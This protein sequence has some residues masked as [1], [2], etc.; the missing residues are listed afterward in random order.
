MT[1]ILDYGAT[2]SAEFTAC[3]TSGANV[4]LVA[5]KD[6]ADGDAIAIYG[7][8]VAH[9]LTKPTAVATVV[10]AP[11]STSHK[12]RVVAFNGRGGWIAS[13]IF[14][15]T[16]G[17]ASPTA[18][19]FVRVTITP[20]A[21]AAGYL[22][23]RNTQPGFYVSSVARLASESMA[24]DD[25]GLVS[26]YPPEGMIHALQHQAASSADI[27]A[28]TIASGGGTLALVLTDAA[29]TN[30]GN[31]RIEHDATGAFRAACAAGGR[32]S[33]PSGTYRL[34]EHVIVTAPVIL[35]GD[36]GGATSSTA[37]VLWCNGLG[38]LEFTTGASWFRMESIA[39]KS[40]SKAAAHHGIHQRTQ[41]TISHCSVSGFGGNGLEL[42]GDASESTNANEWAVEH[43]QFSGCGGWGFHV[44]GGDGNAGNM[45][46]CRAL[47]NGLGGFHEDS[48][49]GNSYQGCH[50]DMNAG[51]AYKS[52]KPNSR[53]LFNGCYA[54]AGQ[55]ANDVRA[56]SVVVG[57]IYGNGWTPESNGL[58]VLSATEISPMQI[59]NTLGASRID[60]Y[61]GVADTTR[62]AFGFKEATNSGKHHFSYGWGPGGNEWG[63]VW[64]NTPG[65]VGLTVAPEARSVKP[66]T[67]G[68][69]EFAVGDGANRRMIRALPGTPTTGLWQPGDVSFDTTGAALCYTPNARGGFHSSVW[70]SGGSYRTG[71]AIRPVTANGYIYRANNNGFAGTT[72]PTWPT[73]VGSTVVDNTITWEC[74]GVSPVAFTAH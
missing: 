19:N 56:P 26:L 72:E 44:S 53:S 24:I 74:W 25:F 7:A 38:G 40:K 4:A 16:N 27:H 34:R 54:E 30:A 33:V 10:G 46:A 6:F 49:L 8:G 13:D 64:N 18:S 1:S 71:H 42:R 52:T 58:R 37:S 57:G 35:L 73:T 20:V 9:G 67:V 50:T 22:L 15:C 51:P 60:T 23:H 12:Y 11:G 48:F 69:P 63:L 5:A 65:Y 28:T 31:L 43:C 59:A 36:G 17:P 47:Y 29:R 61:L 2:G 45:L 39:V 68:L 14:E 3:T 41:G 55:Q 32:C 62:T 70:G 21:G 66:G